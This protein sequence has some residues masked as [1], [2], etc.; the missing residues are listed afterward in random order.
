MQRLG[1]PETDACLPGKHLRNP[2]LLLRLRA[3]L[4]HHQ[5]SWEVADDRRFVLQVVV[6]AETATG[7]VLTHDRHGQVGAVAAPEASRELVAQKAGGIGFASHAAEQRFPL[8]IRETIAI[9]VS[10][11]VL[12]SVVEEADVVVLGLD[13][14]DHIVDERVALIE[15]RL[16]IGWDREVHC[17]T[18]GR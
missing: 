6:Q 18:V 12:A 11:S 14:N 8:G 3:V 10:A 1:E 15:Q 4:L 13:R 5:H 7:E 17:A 2:L 16:D 9:P